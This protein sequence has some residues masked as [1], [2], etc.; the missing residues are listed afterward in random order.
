VNYESVPI[1]NEY[2]RAETYLGVNF[3]KPLKSDHQKTEITTINHVRYPGIPSFLA[4]RNFYSGTVSYL[5]HLNSVAKELKAS[6][7]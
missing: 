3:I 5:K 6:Q 1:N 2:T 4:S 7:S